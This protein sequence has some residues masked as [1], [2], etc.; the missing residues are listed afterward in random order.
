MRSYLRKSFDDDRGSRQLA[1]DGHMHPHR[2]R[3]EIIK[4]ASI[5]MGQREQSKHP[6]S[7]IQFDGT[8][9]K[10]DVPGQTIG[11]EYHPFAESCGSR[12]IVNLHHFAVVHFSILHLFGP[13]SFGE[14]FIEE[15]IQIL[16]GLFECRIR[17]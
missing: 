14:F 5:A 11:R 16:E 4:S 1:Q 2:H 15:L 12:G 8:H 9:G 3:E 6:F 13:K 10:I 7:G 17:C